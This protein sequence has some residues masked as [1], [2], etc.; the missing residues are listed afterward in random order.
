MIVFDLH[1]GIVGDSFV[2]QTDVHDV[3]YKNYKDKCYKR[4]NDA[5]G[6]TH[7]FSHFPIISFL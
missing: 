7:K 2:G 1:N 3:R 6:N 5:C 4:Q